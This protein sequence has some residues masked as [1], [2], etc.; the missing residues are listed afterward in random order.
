LVKMDHA[1]R[2]PREVPVVRVEGTKMTERL[3][4]GMSTV[5]VYD[6]GLDYTILSQRETLSSQQ[7]THGNSLVLFTDGW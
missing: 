1:V 2:I 3:G 4:F 5:G 6:P 7:R